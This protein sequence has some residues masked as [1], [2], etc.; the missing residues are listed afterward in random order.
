MGTMNSLWMATA[1][2]ADP[3]PPLD[4]TVDADVAVIGAG[5]AGLMT[6]VLLREAGFDVAVVEAS[7]VG[8]GVT[9]HSTAK[10][11]SQHGL[12]YARLARDRGEAA[13]RTYAQANQ[14]GLAEYLRLVDRHGIDCALTRAP[15]YV[16]ATGHQQALEVE[17]EAEA[18]QQA[19]LP[20]HLTTDTELPFPVRAAVRFDEQ[21]HVHPRRLCLGLAQA[22]VR[23]GAS[24]YESSRVVEVADGEPCVVRTDRGEVRARRVV[25]TTGL[26][27][28]D[29]GAHFATTYPTRSY[30]LAVTIDGPLPQGMYI[31]ADSPVRSLRPALGKYLIVGGEG[32]KAGQDPDEG[33]HY[34]NLEAWAREH[35]AVQEVAYRWSAHDYQPADGVP[36][37]GRL[38][39]G[40][41]R[42][43]VATGFQKWGFSTAG[44]AARILTDLVAERENAWAE[45]FD[46]SR[47]PRSG[48]TT[49]AGENANVARRFVLDR[50]AS[51]GKPAAD[52]LRPGQAAVLR[53]EGRPVAA[54]RDEDGRLHAVSARCTHL[55]CT[56]AF[57][58]AE[59]TWDC[60]CHGSRFDVDGAVLHGPAVHDLAPDGASGTGAG[61]VSE[62]V[63]MAG[64]QVAAAAGL[65]GSLART[66]AR[67]LRGDGGG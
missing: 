62:V 31:S 57:N 64:H 8:A 61:G 13:A 19:G 37:I 67:A 14:A 1:D 41:E 50:L 51:F 58:E 10:V 15:A 47:L 4:G 54:Y 11:T 24:V 25:V 52:A 30:A 27:I 53:A 3:R 17:L 46:A 38:H 20:A 65:L 35:F 63:Q 45:L 5:I 23:E 16:Y 60:P 56:V 48:A 42:I 33:R 66:A 9:G 39:K 34:D 2:A 43:L 40:T 22:L 32:H 26:P 12:K 29:R 18:A 36:Y 28:L 59:K 49:V 21:A 55:G 7:R 6:A 44:V